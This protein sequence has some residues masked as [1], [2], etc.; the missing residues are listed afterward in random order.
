TG[1]VRIGHNVEFGYY[2]QEQN[3][4]T[5]SNTVLDELHNTYRLYTETEL[6]S[7]LGRFLFR[8]EDV[9]KYVGD[10]SGGE[11]ARLS[12]LKIM[13]SG[14]NCLLMDEPTNHLDIASKE[15]FEDALLEFPGT[16]FVISHDR[17]FLNKIS[18]KIVELSD[19]GL[20]HYAGGYD[21]YL[22]KKES[23]GSG[24]SY[25]NEMAQSS[26]SSASAGKSG[27]AAVSEKEQRAMERQAQKDLQAQRRRL[28]RQMT[29]AEEDIARLEETIAELEGLL[30]LEEV[31]TDF[32][33]S[34]EISE[35]LEQSKSELEVT[36][37][38]WMELQEQ[39]GDL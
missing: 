8:G 15:I 28:E 10:L 16:L 3:L 21:Y 29:K 39:L 35:K 31:Y 7:L 6:R 34:A 14:A 26:T 24:K 38:Q 12:L 5:N 4:L 19:S 36:Y 11:K 17:Y 20:T 23:L 13:M 18:T 9:F 25:L 33:K 1:Y 2:D 22:E 37:T 32:Q 27:A 30:C